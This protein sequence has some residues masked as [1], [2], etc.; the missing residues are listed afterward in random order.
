MVIMALAVTSYLLAEVASAGLVPITTFGL[1]VSLGV[2]IRSSSVPTALNVA[3]VLV[4]LTVLAQL[5][6][7]RGGVT[8]R[9]LMGYFD[10]PIHTIRDRFLRAARFVGIDLRA[11]LH[12][13]RS[14]RF[15]AIV[16]G[17]IL[18]LPLV[19][20]F[21]ML[22]M[23][24]DARF[25]VG[26]TR[27]VAAVVRGG[28]VARMVGALPIVL[29]VVGVWRS[30]RTPIVL[31]PSANGTLRIQQVSG[32]TVPVSLVA[33]FSMFVLSQ[34]IGDR[35]ALVRN[36]DFARNAREGFL[37][38][39]AVT[40]LIVAVLLVLDWLARTED[41]ARSAMFDRLAT[42]LIVLT[43]VVMLSALDHMRLYVDANGLTELRVYTTAFML[44]IGFILVWFARTI[45]HNRHARFAFGL[46]LSGLS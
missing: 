37:E 18:G 21:G 8:N 39:V 31:G 40:A 43:G 41:G 22:F 20:L 17:L 23:A 9:S 33:M 10:Q 35:P 29:V 24:A 6:Q 15:R 42:T 14:E 13:A 4:A 36:I 46:L 12:P 30:A 16:V 19:F 27:L 26:L 2:G 1:A 3:A 44:W 34:V 32:I 5:P 11:E 7:Q 45:L 25:E 38:L 28:S